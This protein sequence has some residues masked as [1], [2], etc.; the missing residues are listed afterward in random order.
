MVRVSDVVRDV[1]ALADS[2]RG[3]DAD[4]VYGMQ[5]VDLINS[6]CK[7]HLNAVLWGN[8]IDL[9]NAA[10]EKGWVV[11]Y[12]GHGT[13][14]KAGAGFVM[15]TYEH[16]YGHTGWVIADSD[17]VTLKTVE[18]NV[19]GYAD[20]NGD[21]VNDQLQFGGPARYVTRSFSDGYG[22][23]VGWFYPPY[24]QVASSATLTQESEPTGWRKLKDE[25][26]TMTVQV[27]AVRVRNSPSVTGQIVATYGYGMSFAYDSVYMGDGYIWVS[28]IS[29]SGVR[30]YV[31][32][33]K[34]EGGRNVAPFGTFA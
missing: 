32:C 19:D 24:D 6:V 7:Q 2:G 22:Y 29:H 26:G 30:R 28:Y 33:G 14:P 34:E 15:A 31:A 8:A 5:C 20:T 17:G 1:K 11:E 27:A 18:Q 21:G 3:V 13:L 10:A 16:P 4:L 25:A 9:L 12:A 23:V